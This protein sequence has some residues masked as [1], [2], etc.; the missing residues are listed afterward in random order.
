MHN[1]QNIWIGKYQLKRA[2]W[3][4]DGNPRRPHALLTS[5]LHS[6][7]FFNSRLVIP[8]EV[9]MREAAADL[10]AKFGQ[11]GGRVWDVDGVIGPQ[12]G[13]TLLAELISEQISAI[14][15]E[16]CFHASPKKDGEGK[17]RKMIFDAEDLGILPGQFVLLCEDVL[18]T[19]LSVDL[20]AAAVAA[21]E[22][23][24]LDCVL[25]LVNR[26][27][28]Q[29]VN[30][31]RVISLIDH[32]MPTWAEGQCPL[33]DSGSKVLPAKDPANWAALNAQYD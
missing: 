15:R 31:R 21:A 1:L 30:G 32:A 18:T 11:S 20:T 23:S 6:T 13:A 14:N 8:D 33:C 26:S 9:M 17:D 16:D 7:G 27:G 4:H 3:I 5:G 29:H 2:L 25:A 28:L 12:T 22:G 10:V 24:I 19:G